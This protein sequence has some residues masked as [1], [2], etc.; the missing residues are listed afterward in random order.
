MCDNRSNKRSQTQQNKKKAT[1]PLACGNAKSHSICKELNLFSC[2]FPLACSVPLCLAAFVASIML[3][4]SHHMER[5]ALI[6][7][8]LGMLL[9]EQTGQG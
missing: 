6:G 4:N 3:I 9:C 7:Q 1:T 8:G 5:V 2:S